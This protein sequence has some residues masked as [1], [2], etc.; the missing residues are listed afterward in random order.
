VTFHEGL[1]SAGATV[2]P[3]GT[4]GTETQVQLIRDLGVTGYTGTPS[5]LNAVINKAEDMGYDFK[6]DFRSPEG[7]FCRPNLSS[8]HSG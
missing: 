7:V 5:F 1:R 3:S 2:I 4:S 6:K 8:H